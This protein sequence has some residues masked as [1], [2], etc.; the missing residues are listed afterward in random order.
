L[1]KFFIIF[2]SFIHFQ[3][4]LRS[5]SYLYHHQHEDYYCLCNVRFSYR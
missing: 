5:V 1:K 2:L 4:S 3:M